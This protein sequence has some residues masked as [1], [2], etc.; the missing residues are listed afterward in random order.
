MHLQII[1]EEKSFTRWITNNSLFIYTVCLQAAAEF[2]QRKQLYAIAD[3]SV[4]TYTMDD[5]KSLQ[6]VVS[7]S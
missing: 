7:Q 6:V 1:Y 5:S 2:L 4:Y 3:S